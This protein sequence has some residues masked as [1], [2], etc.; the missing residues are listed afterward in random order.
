MRITIGANVLNF[1][2]DYVKRSKRDAFVRDQAKALDHLGIDSETLK[3]K[4]GEAHDLVN[5]RKPK[6]AKP[7]T[8]AEE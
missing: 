6:A 4:L 5:G 8:E 1:W 3:E 2:D 7:P